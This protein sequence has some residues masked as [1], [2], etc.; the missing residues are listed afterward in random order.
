MPKHIVLP[1]QAGIF[2]LSREDLAA[3]KEA[4][5][6]QGFAFFEVDLQRAT[7]VPGFIRALKRDLEFPD[8]FG[9]NLDALNDCLTDFSWHPASGYVITLSGSATLSATPTS[10]A[11]LNAVLACAVDEWRARNVPFLVF[12]LTDPTGTANGQRYH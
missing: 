3:L 12:Y 11:T 1:S 10:F 5:N 9:G 7:N 4:A 8:W 6:E 2:R